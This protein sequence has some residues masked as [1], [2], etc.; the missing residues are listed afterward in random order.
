MA[1]PKRLQPTCQQVLTANGCSC[2][3]TVCGAV[4]DESACIEWKKKC[5]AVKQLE[6]EK[7][8][9]I[10]IG[11]LRTTQIRALSG[12][13]SYTDNLQALNYQLELELRKLKVLYA[14]CMLSVPRTLD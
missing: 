13:P 2:D 14:R 4:I 8:K 12:K 11:I 9:D 6:N 10:N 3:G 5:I 1:I 7:E